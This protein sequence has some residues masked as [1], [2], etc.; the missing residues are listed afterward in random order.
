MIKDAAR[1]LWGT[2]RAARTDAT[3]ER[4][5]HE[6]GMVN[7]AGSLSA[8]GRGA[9][10][11]NLGD[12]V[13]LVLMA[14]PEK[15]GGSLWAQVSE[16]LETTDKASSFGNQ[17]IKMT[18]VTVFLKHQKDREECERLVSQ[19]FGSHSP[20]VNY[21]FQP[22]GS[23]ALVAMEAWGIGGRDIRIEH[24]EPHVMSVDYDSMRWIYCGGI[25][26]PFGASGAHH[27]TN[28]A[29]DA[30][31]RA[32]E[33]VG[34]SF[35]DVVRTWFYLGDITAAEGDNQRYQEMNRARTDFYSEICFGRFLGGGHQLESGF[36][37]STGIGM[38]SKDLVIGCIAMQTQRRDVRLL[39]LENPQQTPAYTY[40]PRYSPKSPKFSRAMALVLGDYTTTWIS[41]TASIVNSESVFTGD[42]VRQTEQTIDNIERLIAPANYAGHGAPG[43]GATLGDLAKVR[44][45]IKRPE[46]YVRCKAVCQRR[47]GNIPAIYVFADVCRPE[48]LV[49]IEGVAFSRNRPAC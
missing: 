6:A 11:V 1:P 31:R 2:K 43:A 33:S 47:F 14:T 44:V 41:G 23:G 16:L 40:H 25:H 8:P 45:Y 3:V 9:A 18:S 17:S 46:D 15:P 19:H 12:C 35:E 7:V 4:S 5:L 30:T 28:C 10:S 39:T 20:V 34:A 32:L 29:L 49:E 13:R 26:V 24:H 42:I 22:P 36:P 38:E 27:Q 37:A 48:L 21:V